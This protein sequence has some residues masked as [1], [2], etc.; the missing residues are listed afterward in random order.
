[1]QV[2]AIPPE[3]PVS[4]LTVVRSLPPDGLLLPFPHGRCFVP[5]AQIVALHAERNYTC[6]HFRDGRT[7]LYSRT[8]G[9]LLALL[10]AQA[11]ARIHRSHAVNRQ[12]ISTVTK[13]QIVLTDG[14]TWVV[15]RR[16][17]DRL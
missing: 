11:F 4:Q 10:P 8:L 13:S 14:S 5:A 7:L 2:H 15:S 12:Y 9:D 1:M 17:Q 6:L 16:R 3:L